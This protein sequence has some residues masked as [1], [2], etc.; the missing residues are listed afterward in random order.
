MKG[1]QI[2]KSL[3][4]H[5][6]WSH[7]ICRRRNNFRPVDLDN[8]PASF[9]Q[10]QQ[11]STAKPIPALK[12]EDF[13]ALDP[14]SAPQ[15]RTTISP[16]YD[17]YSSQVYRLGSPPGSGTD[18]YGYPPHPPIFD[19]SDAVSPNKSSVDPNLFRRIPQPSVHEFPP[20]SNV[21]TAERKGTA[22]R[23]HYPIHSRISQ[24]PEYRDRSPPSLS[25]SPQ[26][27]ASSTSRMDYP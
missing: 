16:A 11:P 15:T 9:P 5:P 10:G 20:L 4:L 3:H 19:Q 17:P 21:Q 6:G 22:Q 26:R 25:T 14:Q 18:Y 2:L 23:H 27:C 13:P 24:R 8:L 12:A 1:I 7:A